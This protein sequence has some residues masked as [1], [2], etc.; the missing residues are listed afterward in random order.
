MV[1]LA[2]REHQWCNWLRARRWEQAVP[3]DWQELD[4]DASCLGSETAGL[5]DVLSGT[6]GLDVNGTD[7]S[8]QGNKH[9]AC[10]LASPLV[11]LHA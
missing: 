8:W 1:Y 4:Y 5:H 6:E 9:S 10:C 7:M 2:E 11:S 3:T